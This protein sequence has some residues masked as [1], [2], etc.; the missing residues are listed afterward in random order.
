MKFGGGS[1]PPTRKETDMPRI[2]KRRHIRHGRFK[3]QSRSRYLMGFLKA[4]NTAIGATGASATVA[5]AAGN[6][7]TWTAHGRTVGS[8]PYLFTT[9]GT[10][11][12]GLLKDTLY[13]IHTVVDVNTIRV[14]TQLGSPASN[15]VDA[16]SGTHTITKAGTTEAMFNYLRKVEPLQL[17]KTTDVD[18]L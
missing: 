9:S 18:N 6:S 11:P 4:R 5:A 13:W 10:L 12:T 7:L 2:A 16:G 3:R 8:G 1:L 15:V 17:S 14:T